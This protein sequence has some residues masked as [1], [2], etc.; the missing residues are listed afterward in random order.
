MECK[1]YTIIVNI[2]EQSLVPNKVL[3]KAYFIRFES[4]PSH[5]LSKCIAIFN[6]KKIILMI[7]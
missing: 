4:T 6:I 1:A 7:F 3:N 5:I 2:K